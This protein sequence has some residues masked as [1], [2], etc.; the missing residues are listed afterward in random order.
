MLFTCSCDFFD[1]AY[2]IKR[3]KPLTAE[4]E[5]ELAILIRQGD[6]NARQKLIDNYLPF[7]A[8]TIKK[9]SSNEPSLDLIYRA[10]TVLNNLIDSHDFSKENNSFTRALSFKLHQT[11]TNFIADS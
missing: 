3:I 2:K 6:E 5:K 4:E 10:I 1:Y 8:S 11:L 9:Y 7:V